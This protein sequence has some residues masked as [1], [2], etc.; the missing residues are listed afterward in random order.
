MRVLPNMVSDSRTT[1]DVVWKGDRCL[2]VVA[3]VTMHDS[4]G[5]M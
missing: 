3:T 2:T 5:Y 4:A 1:R